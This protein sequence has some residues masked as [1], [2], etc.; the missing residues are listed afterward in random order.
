MMKK[1]RMIL[2][3]GIMFAVITTGLI[4]CG[5][6]AT[7]EKSFTADEVNR[8]EIE[9]NLNAVIIRAASGDQLT[10]SIDGQE[11]KDFYSIKDN[12]LTIKVGEDDGKTKISLGNEENKSLYL[13]IPAGMLESL[14]I[15]SEMGNVQVIGIDVPDLNIHT[16]MGNITITGMEGSV[17]AEAAAG[18]IESSLAISSEIEKGQLSS[19]LAGKIGENSEYKITVSTDMGNIKFE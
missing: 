9:T 2:M 17:E 5:K 1:A 14:N 4:A 11:T 12:V 18:K 19:T 15:E 10:M 6:T 3:M 7:V 8:I 13:D 16:G